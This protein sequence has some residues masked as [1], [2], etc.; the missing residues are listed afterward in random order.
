MAYYVPGCIGNYNFAIVA[1]F[2]RIRF[3][4]GCNTIDLMRNAST[5]RE[6]EEIALVVMLDLNDKTV[7]DLKLDCKHA[8]TCE[9]TICRNLLIKMI[10][11]GLD[12]KNNSLIFQL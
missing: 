12:Q 2:A 10:N 6:K 3:I 7:T 5:H 11:K 9:I 1:L 8:G 4:E